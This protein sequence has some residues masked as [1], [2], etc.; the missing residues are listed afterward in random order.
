MRNHLLTIYKSVLLLLLLQSM[1]AWFMWNT[2][3]LVVPLAAMVSL[4]FWALYKKDQRLFVLQKKVIFPILMLIIFEIYLALNGNLNS[5]IISGFRIIIF[6]ILLLTQKNIKIK[7]LHFITKSFAFILFISIVTWIIHLLGIN[8]PHS[9]ISY[10][11]GMYNYSNYYFFLFDD[12][13]IYVLLPRFSSIFLEPGHLGMITSFLLFANK[14]ELKRKEVLIIFIATIMTFSLAAYVLLMI[15][16][17]IFIIVNSKR[18][19][20]NLVFAIVVVGSLYT[21]FTT[22]NDGDNVVNDYILLRLQ[23]ED[24]DLAGNNRFSNA[25][26][27]YYAQIMNS[28]QKLLGVG[29]QEYNKQQITQSAGYKVYL[30]QYGIIGTLITFFFYFS[31]VQIKPSKL[32]YFFLLVYVLSFLQRAYPH[33]D[34]EIIIFIIGISYLNTSKKQEN[35]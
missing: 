22:Y 35:K 26:D 33:W 14:F 10:G 25:L 5:L 21:F 7:I 28:P 19:I 8:L 18:A 27:D 1:Q 32:A 9:E 17:F 23:I 3:K 11:D 30:V 16:A 15:S 13:Q 2:Y 4:L 6:T 31:I 24:G 29:M 12:R 34:V 20:L